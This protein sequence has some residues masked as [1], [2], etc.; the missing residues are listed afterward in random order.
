MPAAVTGYPA[1]VSGLSEP[2]AEVLAGKAADS[3]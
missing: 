1:I 3:D 2:L